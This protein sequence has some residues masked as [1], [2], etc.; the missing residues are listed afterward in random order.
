[1]YF[2]LN[3]ILTIILKCWTVGW[4]VILNKTNF[5][6]HLT[7]TKTAILV[8]RSISYRGPFLVN[9]TVM[10]LLDSTTTLLLTWSTQCYRPT[11]STASTDPSAF[12]YRQ[13][14]WPDGIL[15]L[16]NTLLIKFDRKTYQDLSAHYEILFTNVPHTFP[17]HQTHCS[18][19]IH[20]L[21]C[22]YLAQT[23]TPW[24]FVDA[25]S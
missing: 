18:Y 24:P 8:P 7:V 13:C 23:T 17:F 12:A 4:M 22:V 10:L 9:L 3:K 15:Y 6:D 5:F 25:W 14:L 1:M 11:I 19:D 16:S 20:P 21:N 2:S